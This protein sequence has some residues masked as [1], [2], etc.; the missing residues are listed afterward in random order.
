MLSPS[1]RVGASPTAQRRIIDL[2]DSDEDI[3]HPASTTFDHPATVLEDRV[4]PPQGRNTHTGDRVLAPSFGLS[5]EEK[6]EPF[7]MPWNDNH[8]RNTF[9]LGRDGSSPRL[10]DQGESSRH[11]AVH[12]TYSLHGGNVSPIYSPQFSEEDSRPPTPVISSSSSSI[13]DWGALNLDQDPRDR[14]TPTPAMQNQAV[15]HTTG[16]LHASPMRSAHEVID[17]SLL[18][19]D[20]LLE[21][22]ADHPLDPE[23]P[24]AATSI[25][26]DLTAPSPKLL[27]D[28]FATQVL[29][30]F[31]DVS[32]DHLKV[33]WEERVPPPNSPD[34]PLFEQDQIAQAVILQ[35]VEKSD[36]PREKPKTLASK[37]KRS[38]TSENS[39]DERT[40]WKAKR[41]KLQ[42]DID[43]IREMTITLLNEF[44]LVPSEHVKGV[45][46]GQ[47]F[48]YESLLALAQAEKKDPKEQGYQRLKQAR[49]PKMSPHVPPK[50]VAEVLNSEF[51]AARKLISKNEA[52][53]KKLQ[54]EKDAEVAEQVLAEETG[55]IVECQCCF[56]DTPVSRA[57][58]CNGDGTHFFCRDCALSY[59][60]AQT[61]KGQHLLECFATTECKAEFSHSHKLRFLD[62]EMLRLLDKLE[63]N[64]IMRLAEIEGL[65]KCPFCDYAE[66]YPDVSENKIFHCKASACMKASCRLCNLESHVPKTCAEAKAENGISERHI[67]E[68]AMTKA[69]VRNCP[70]CETPI[71]KDSGCNKM[72]CTKCKCAI[73]DYCGKDISK[74]GYG[75]FAGNGVGRNGGCP[76]NDDTFMRNDTRVKAAEKEAMARIRAENPELSEEDLKIKFSEKVNT[77]PNAREGAQIPP[78]R[79]NPERDPLLEFGDHFAPFIPYPHGRRFHGRVLDPPAYLADRAV[80]R[81]EQNGFEPR[82]APNPLPRPDYHAML[83]DMRRRHSI[84]Q[85]ALDV[86]AAGLDAL[87]RAAQREPGGLYTFA[88]NRLE[89]RFGPFE[90]DARRLRSL[91]DQDLLN[92]R[93][94][95]RE[96]AARRR[97]D[98]RRRNEQLTAERR[99]RLDDLRRRTD[100]MRE[101]QT[102]RNDDLLRDRV[103]RLDRR[104]RAHQGL[105]AEDLER[106]M[107]QPWDA[108]DDL[109]AAIEQ[110]APRT[111]VLHA[112]GAARAHMPPPLARRDTSLRAGN[113]EPRAASAAALRGP[114]LQYPNRHAGM[115]APAVAAA[116][117]AAA[118][119]AAGAGA[120]FVLGEPPRSRRERARLVVGSCWVLRSWG[121][122]GGFLWGMR[123]F[124]MEKR[125][126][127]GEGGG[128][129]EGVLW[130]LVLGLGM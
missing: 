91:R 1:H 53:R 15:H 35:L 70:K 59:A 78:Y 66:I 62:A 120:N 10:I 109:P 49:K 72:I 51:A 94:E 116:A 52:H 130:V 58:H 38:I 97:E 34:R 20:A 76:T 4:V 21:Y 100:E 26:I 123:R 57:V 45:C 40:D 99:Q 82:P 92:R 121:T 60:K 103:E 95:V 48:L 89:E 22:L 106:V 11:A 86:G 13:S 43:Y 17:L 14:H 31:P 129:V 71:L 114:D 117:A 47:T 42:H 25:P 105:P 115:P 9:P 55:A 50:E 24:Q 27:Y 127:S 98:L 32:L 108:A 81:A 33:L 37:R 119:A 74:E 111:R 5:D 90:D 18:D 63:Q 79:F 87:N 7:P 101:A 125:N 85:P 30:V 102:P 2:D 36:Y 112:R 93:I 80:P 104:L 64:D 118:G 65:A 84:A 56:T 61:D 8:R 6:W 77:G 39:E 16:P 73:C 69:L 96:D 110:R 124:A 29:E 44:L 41:V 122:G 107:I 83:A 12:N 67:L 75:H 88:M 54:E 113:E 68:E 126:G 46:R 3:W 28:V 128:G 23:L 19:D